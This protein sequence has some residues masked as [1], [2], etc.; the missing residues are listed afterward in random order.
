MTPVPRHQSAHPDLGQPGWT[1][2]LYAVW[3]GEML[4]LIGFSSRVPF[5]PF[6]LGDLGVTDVD[7]QLLWSGGINAVGA[8]AMALTA[9]L[10]GLLADRYGRKPMLLR[11]LFGGAIVVALMG[12][13]TAPWQ[14]VALRVAEGTLTGTVAAATALIATSAPKPRLGY[15]LGMVQ[16]AVFAGAAGGPLLGGIA[17]D[18]LGPRGTFLLAGAMLGSGGG[19]GPRLFWGGAGGPGGPPPPR[20]R[21]PAGP[22]APRPRPFFL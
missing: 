1:L 8:A 2:T 3:A 5:L 21:R 13:S 19:V 14:L 11:G 6:F 12:F 20:A 22:P 10:W 4:A 9:P 16:T 17:Y 7:N 15:A 18:S